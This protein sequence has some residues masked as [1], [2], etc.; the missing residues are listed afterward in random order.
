LQL[1]S[2]LD[3][4]PPAATW[5]RAMPW[6]QR[7][8]CHRHAN[9]TVVKSLSLQGVEQRIT[10]TSRPYPTLHS[11]RYP[12][13]IC[14]VLRCNAVTWYITLLVQAVH[15]FVT[16]L[17]NTINYS[18]SILFQ[19]F[20]EETKNSSLCCFHTFFILVIDTLTHVLQNDAPVTTQNIARTRSLLSYSIQH[21][22]IH[23]KPLSDCSARNQYF[24]SLKLEAP[25]LFEHVLNK[26]NK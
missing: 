19:M 17:S 9:T 14:N 25:Y 8:T 2:V 13:W 22:Q 4:V 21:S 18:F 11:L 23:Y 12:F 15:F 16:I 1:A 26:E 6:W 7:S 3:A 5:G 20:L 10:Q 24:S